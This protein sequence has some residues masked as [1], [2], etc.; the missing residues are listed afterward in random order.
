MSE[1][2][3]PE[4]YRLLQKGETIQEGD[5]YLMGNVRWIEISPSVCNGKWTPSGYW[6][7]ARKTEKKE[8][9][10]AA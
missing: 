7:M 6:P 3:A 10:C 1:V 5:L 9:E 4:G 8:K 2:V